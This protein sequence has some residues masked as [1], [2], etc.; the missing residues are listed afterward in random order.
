MALFNAFFGSI[1]ANENSNFFQRT[2]WTEEAIVFIDFIIIKKSLKTETFALN[3]SIVLHLNMAYN[4]ANNCTALDNTSLQEHLAEVWNELLSSSKLA[5]N[6]V[7]RTSLQI[8]YS[9]LSKR[10]FPSCQH[11][12][13]HWQRQQIVRLTWKTAAQ[14]K[15]WSY[16]GRKDINMHAFSAHYT[17]VCLHNYYRKYRPVANSEVPL[18]LS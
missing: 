3:K 18:N 8:M 16:I 2:F 1:K 14:N 4:Y 11:G 13:V 7:C 6:V 5:Q 17:T 12:T 15:S 9:L 10:G